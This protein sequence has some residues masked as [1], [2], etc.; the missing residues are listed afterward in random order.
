MC[1]YAAFKC[2]LSPESFIIYAGIAARGLGGG[3]VR[4]RGG[5]AGA[6]AVVYGHECAAAKRR[7]AM[8]GMIQNYKRSCTAKSDLK[9]EK[10]S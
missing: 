8:N 4:C 1:Q 7:L 6:E 5:G 3:W 9:L 2:N 10:I